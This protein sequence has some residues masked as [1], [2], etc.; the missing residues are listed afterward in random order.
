MQPDIDDSTLLERQGLLPCNRNSDN[1]LW[2]LLGTGY[3]RVTQPGVSQ[4]GISISP[5]DPKTK[6]TWDVQGYLSGLLGP[7][8][9]GAQGMFEHDCS[10]TDDLNSFT[11]ALTYDLRPSHSK[12]FWKQ[13]GG[14]RGADCRGEAGNNCS[15]PILGVRPVEFMGRVGWEWPPDAFKYPTPK[16]RP[17][18][19]PQYL[20][21][22]FN[23]VTGATLR[24]PLVWSPNRHHP[25]QFTVAPVLG[26]EFGDRLRSHP[27]CITLTIT[28]PCTPQPQPSGILRGVAGLDASARVPYNFTKDF[29]GDKPITLDYS[30]RTRWLAKEEPFADQVGVA[31]N[32]KEIAAG[33]VPA[34]VL[35]NESHS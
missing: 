29:F 16:S 22:N 32:V 21:R 5:I 15:P 4:G 34:T 31:Y 23:F 8:W 30:Y 19:P 33:R 25:S 13:W 18:Q 3:T 26:P 9:L 17:S 11:T 28:A 10:P 1:F 7:G 24:F 2:R 14:D 27:I 12:P 20:A 35:I 6:S